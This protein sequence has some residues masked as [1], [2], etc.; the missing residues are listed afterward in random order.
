MLAFCCSDVRYGHEHVAPELQKE[1]VYGL[2]ELFRDKA[3]TSTAL[4]GLPIA[5]IPTNGTQYLYASYPR[6]EGHLIET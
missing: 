3:S 1:A 6:Q 2:T 5:G 4:L